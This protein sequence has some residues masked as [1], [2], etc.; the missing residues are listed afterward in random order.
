MNDTGSEN[1]LEDADSRQPLSIKELLVIV[2]S[3]HIGVRKRTH[4]TSDFARAKGLHVF[5]AA[6][7]YF[8]VI[9][10]GLVFLV[11]YIAG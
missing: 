10:I 8:S 6:L 7:L 9:V 4:R 3:G 5:L 2:L 11:T 1:P